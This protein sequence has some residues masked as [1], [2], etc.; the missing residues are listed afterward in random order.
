MP[1]LNF[2]PLQNA[3]AALRKS[4]AAYDSAWSKGGGPALPAATRRSSTP[5]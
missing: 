5:S 1:Y 4:A 2:A 3:V